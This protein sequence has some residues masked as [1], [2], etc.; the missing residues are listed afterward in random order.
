DDQQ[1]PKPPSRTDIDPSIPGGE[2]SNNNNEDME[3]QNDGVL[4]PAA[5]K[6]KKKKKP[7][8]NPKFKDVQ[9]TG[10]WG[11]MSKK[12]VIIAIAIFL[13]VIVAVVLVVLFVV[14]LPNNKE[15]N[16]SSNSGGEGGEV[17]FVP[18]PTSPPTMPPTSLPVETELALVLDAIQASP[19]TAP[20]IEDGD[21]S[22][23]FVVFYK[24]LVDNASATPQQKAMSWLLYQDELKDPAQS[25]QRF[26]FASM[27]FQNG[28]SSWA[29]S[30]GW[31]TSAPLCEWDHINCDSRGVLQ[32]VDFSE[33]NLSGDIAIEMAM[34]GDDLQSI[35]MSRNSLSGPIPGDIFAELPVLGL[36]Y[37]DNNILT[38]SVPETLVADAR[39]RKFWIE[40][41]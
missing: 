35:I 26:A 17:S 12:E 32:E 10:K 18:A 3:S 6:K 20:L 21:L 31:L 34:M 25:V 4:K 27:Y 29:T 1:Q 33:Q 2:D 40:R 8:M 13:V 16:N 24:D 15:D 5:K 28:G 23:E 39:L 22:S 30:E 9:E 11:E 14:V 38:G 41:E 37:L 19:V 7:Q 36:L